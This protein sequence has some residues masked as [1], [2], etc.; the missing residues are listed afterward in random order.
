MAITSE[1]TLEQARSLFKT[2]R[3][4]QMRIITKQVAIGDNPDAVELT[5]SQMGTLMAIKDGGQ[6]SLK[7]IAEATHVSAPSASTMVE[8]LQEMGLLTRNL[9]ENDRRTVEIAITEKGS[10]ALDFTENCLL[11]GLVEIVEGIGPEWTSNWCD[12]YEQI[13]AY[14]DGQESSD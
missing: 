1:H 13:N 7:A 9:A 14:M 10:S 3:R 5:P 8:K 6:L 4:L 12:V 11:Q 2:I